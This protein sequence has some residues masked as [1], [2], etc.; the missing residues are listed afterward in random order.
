METHLTSFDISKIKSVEYIDCSK[1]YDIEV[2]QNHN[3]YLENNILVHNSGKT[4]HII[5]KLILLSFLQEYNH[6]IYVN[7]IFGDIRKNQFKDIIKVLKALELSKY[8]TI[9][10]TNYGF[11]NNL[12]GTEFTALGMDNAENTKGLSDPTI[13]WW[14]EINKGSQED[15]TTLNALLRTPLNNKLQF[16]ISFNPVSEKS[17]L[18]EFFFKKENAY[19]IKEDIESIY[20]N[21]STYIN[22]DFI[23][24]E[25]YLKTL[26][27]NTHGNGNRNLVDIKGLW[28]VEINNN[29][30]FYALNKDAHF[31]EDFY[32]LKGDEIFYLSFDFNKDPCTLVIFAV[33]NKSISIIDLI[34]ANQFTI[35]D[36]TP[37][38]AVCELFIRK[39][40]NSGLT[41]NS[42]LKITGDASGR[43]GGANVK[44]NNSFF[45]IIQDLL[46]VN[47]SQLLLRKAN[48]THLL[49]Q[50]ICNACIFATDFKMYKSAKL[51]YEDMEVAYI[52]NGSLDKCKKELGLH[53]ADAVRYGIDA[54]LMHDRW[55]EFLIY[56]KKQIIS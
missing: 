14:D 9:N 18:R 10:K 46:R 17:W 30:F 27:L 39:Y 41:L 54:I 43:H 21:H 4:H 38:E 32:T 37:I 25:T 7:K 20:L 44:A 47:K 53:I 56:Y 5:L 45:T 55:K 48:T 40:I 23:D 19:E 6:I 12:T 29:P 33:S 52:D 28:G 2:E 16:I 42:K 1:V 49:S 3:Y 36:K 50:E 24:K 13:I 22:N 34:Q 51:I 15:F 35:Q 31:V 26:Q 8:F 11:K